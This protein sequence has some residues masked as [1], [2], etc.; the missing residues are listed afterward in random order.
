[1]IENDTLNHNMDF[2]MNERVKGT[3]MLY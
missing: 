1:M 2:E 3:Y